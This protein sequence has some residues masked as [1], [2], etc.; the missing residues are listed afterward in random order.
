MRF[1]S[2]EIVPSGLV[3]AL[4]LYG[5]IVGLVVASTAEA[6]AFREFV[7][8]S[9]H[10]DPKPRNKQRKLKHVVYCSMSRASPIEIQS[11]VADSCIYDY[12]KLEK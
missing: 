8:G 2:A 11:D 1:P 12:I 5:L 3:Q 6:K 10:G 7:G 9:N 4:G